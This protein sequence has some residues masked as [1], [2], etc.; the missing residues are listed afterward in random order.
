MKVKFLMFCVND[1]KKNPNQTR[2]RNYR[3]GIKHLRVLM[4][5]EKS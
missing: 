2:I 5:T 3:P 1:E 4:P